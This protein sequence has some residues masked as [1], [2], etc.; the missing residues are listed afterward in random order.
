MT[1]L[2]EQ[3]RPK[4]WADVVAQDKAIAKIKTVGRRGLAGRAFWVSGGSGTGKTTLARL[5]AA[6]V[7]TDP[8]NIVELD[9]GDLT[10]ARL[11]T[12]EHDSMYMGWGGG[13]VAYLVNEAHALRRDT[14]K[15]LLVMLER[16]RAHV[17]IIFTTTNEGQAALFD[18]IEDTA[19]LMSRCIQIKLARR[20]LAG[21]FAAR[22]R[23]IATKEGLNGKPLEAYKRLANKCKSNMRAMIQ[24]VESGEMLE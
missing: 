5:I 21:A 24:A 13:G 17:V 23:E 18:G 2:Y 7:T 11:R 6:D 14:V 9:A 15:Q 1:A 16:L 22:V 20:D 19:P 12:I 3:Y 10:P 4:T 8:L